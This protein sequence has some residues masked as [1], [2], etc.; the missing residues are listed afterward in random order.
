[1]I[2]ASNSHQTST[3]SHYSYSHYFA[4]FKT[5]EKRNKA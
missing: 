1:V 4:K 5:L 2:E 3:A